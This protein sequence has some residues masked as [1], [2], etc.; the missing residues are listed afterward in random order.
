MS[1]NA[2]TRE[3]VLAATL[4][5]VLGLALVTGTVYVAGLCLALAG[6]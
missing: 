1:S 3:L 5:L 2:L 6:S 4:D